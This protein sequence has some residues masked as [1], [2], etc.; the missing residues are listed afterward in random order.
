MRW[1]GKGARPC[2]RWR[3]M[4]ST[5]MSRS[6]MIVVLIGVAL[7][8][9][10]GQRPQ[11]DPNSVQLTANGKTLPASKAS[12]AP[13]PAKMALLPFEGSWGR[14]PADCDLSRD[15]RRGTLKIESGRVNYCAAGGPIERILAQ[16]PTSLT[17][18]LRLTGFGQTSVVRSTF[19]L[20]M[21]GT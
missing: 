2:D 18:D 17:L 19:A 9:C 21:A 12:P 8:G 15:D 11:F 16:S 5:E 1:T 10:G 7:T 4:W 3:V 13:T 14:T 20:Q 6:M